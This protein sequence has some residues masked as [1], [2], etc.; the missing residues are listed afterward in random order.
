MLEAITSFLVMIN[1]FALFLYLRPVMNDLSAAQFRR[2]L[3]RAS[4]ISFVIFMLFMATGDAL[5]TEVLNVRFHSF[6][7]FGGIV[8]FSF[9]Y[10]FIVKGE[11]A[12][13][14][15]REDLTEL[16]SGIALPFMVGAGTI[17]LVTLMGNQLGFGWATL[18]I[19][20]SLLG[21]F[22]IVMTMKLIRE[23][24]PNPLFQVAFD[25]LMA[26]FLRVNGFFLGAIGVDMIVTSGVEL[27]RTLV[28]GGEALVAMG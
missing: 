15:T 25:K 18:A 20:I 21:T 10:L 27:Y 24:I 2:V 23:H 9:A 19:V 17:S 4:L 8:I 13:I 26:I 16:A 12:L 6:R 22:G 5:F 7:L 1:P 3:I 28:S 14:Q 11:A